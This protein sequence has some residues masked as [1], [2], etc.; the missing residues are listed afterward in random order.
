MA[1]I[2]DFNLVFEP[3]INNV[4]IKDIEVNIYKNIQ[5]NRRLEMLSDIINE[6]A[7]DTKYYNIGKLKIF[8]T[9][10]TVQYYTDI[11]MEFDNAKKIYD[12]LIHSS[13]YENIV[14]N[15]DSQEIK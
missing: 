12:Y 5:F 15:I 1:K 3:N 9:L 11:E 2:T 4:N 10:F 14:A 7:D 8:F 13:I 6:S